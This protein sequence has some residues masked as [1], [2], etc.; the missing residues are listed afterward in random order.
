M[1]KIVMS[2]SVLTA[3][4]ILLA[5]CKGDAGPAGATGTTG[6]TGPTGATG[7]TGTANVIYSNWITVTNSE[8]SNTGQLA[9][10]HNKDLTAPGVTT[11]IVNQGVV[12]VY[13]YFDTPNQIRLLPWFDGT[14]L[15]SHFV[16]YV[17][18]GIIRVGTRRFDNAAFIN[19]YAPIY[20]RYIL[21]PGGVSGGRYT[22][23][24]LAGYTVDQVK[25]M[26][27][28]QVIELLSIPDAGTNIK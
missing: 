27:Y 18:V 15:I 2:L 16:E 19:N 20:Y 25:S 8:W 6:P 17:Q 26:D 7:A 14:F 3:F 11:A 28:K 23:G 12:L 5:G 24:Q 13:M 4:F 9:T 10:S 1:K 21:I 22:S